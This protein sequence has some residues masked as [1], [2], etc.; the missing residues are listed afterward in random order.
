MRN[1]CNIDFN[2]KERNSIFNSS[3]RTNDTSIIVEKLIAQKT[4]IKIEVTG[5][6]GN[7][8]QYSYTNNEILILESLFNGNGVMKVR[9]TSNELNSEYIIFNCISFTN[10]ND[11]YCKNKNDQFY[12]T[13]KIQ[14]VNELYPVGSIY[15]T[16]LN[17]NPSVAFGGKWER[18][19]VGKTIIGVDEND[20]DYSTVKKTG[21]TKTF[22]NSHSHSMSHTHAVNGHT[23]G[24]NAVALT[25]AQ[26]PVHT[27][28]AGFESDGFTA[29]RTGV[30]GGFSVGFLNDK[31]GEIMAYRQPENAGSGQTHSHGNTASSGTL[32]SNGA[33]VSS[34]GS[35]GQSN[36]SVVQPFITTYIWVRVE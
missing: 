13:M 35:N 7:V 10:N 23:H 12:F 20:N 2:S 4:N 31:S 17:I 36:Q 24:T 33:S 5:V 18:Y 15:M 14:A 25:V 1:I 27:H 22:N 26:M 6:K 3:N 34:T 16:V 9:V 29:H 28:S 32:T 11:I 30:T 19:A 8:I 21:G